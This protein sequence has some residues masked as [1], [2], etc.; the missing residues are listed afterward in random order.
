MRC[1]FQGSV[2]ASRSFNR[3]SLRSCSSLRRADEVVGV[4]AD[5]RGQLVQ[6]DG[7]ERVRWCGEKLAKVAGLQMVGPRR[8]GLAKV[9]RRLEHIE[10]N[11]IFGETVFTVRPQGLERPQ[12]NRSTDRTT[13]TSGLTGP[14]QPRLAEIP[15]LE[16]LDLLHTWIIGR[17]S[18]ADDPPAGGGAVGCWRSDGSPARW[19]P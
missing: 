1:R 6:L 13:Q 7:P 8:P 4:S 3:S 14:R 9:L 10:Q 15:A 17:R 19:S 2:A 18:D 5:Q 12:R 16:D 11:L